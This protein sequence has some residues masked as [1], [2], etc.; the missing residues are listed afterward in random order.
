MSKRKRK[1]SEAFDDIN[2]TSPAFHDEID[3]TFSDHSPL[4]HSSLVYSPVLKHRSCGSA[5]Y[6]Y[7]RLFT[8]NLTITKF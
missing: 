2:A 6:E 3:A 8:L 7:A 4:E 5:T 1:V